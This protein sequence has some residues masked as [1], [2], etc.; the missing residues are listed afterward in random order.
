[1][2][3]VGKIVK[4]QG[5]RGEV[6]AKIITSFPEHFK[7]LTTL[8][9]DNNGYQAYSV[10]HV[11]ISDRFVFIKFEGVDSRSDAEA[12]RN[13]Y[14]YIPEEELRELEADSFYVHDL[15]GV[16]VLSE[17]G[18]LLGR[19]KDVNSYAGNDVYT[20]EDDEGAE[21]MIPAIKDIVIDVDIQKKTMTIRLLD[22]LFE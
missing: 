21:H 18:R 10:D 19:I 11:R 6:K 7:E 4:P 20:I 14:L 5:I 2:F 15:I 16:Q 3:V 1:M 22:G 8:Y 17:Q 12:L 9:V 13:M